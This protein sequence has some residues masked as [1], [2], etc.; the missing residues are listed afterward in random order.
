MEAFTAWP[1]AGQCTLAMPPGSSAAQ[2]SRSAC[3]SCGKAPGGLHV[4][5]L[6]RPSATQCHARADDVVCVVQK[7]Q[8][9]AS[10]RA[11]APGAAACLVSHGQKTSCCPAA[12]ASVVTQESRHPKQGPMPASC[13]AACMACRHICLLHKV[14][15]MLLPLPEGFAAYAAV[16]WQVLHQRSRRW[17]SRWLDQARL[18]CCDATAPLFLQHALV[19]MSPLSAAVALVHVNPGAGLSKGCTW[20]VPWIRIRCRGA[21]WEMMLRRLRASERPSLSSTSTFAFS[22]TSTSCSGRFG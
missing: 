19:S 11:M 5:K 6:N 21:M 10:D 15:Q 17:C 14:L 9:Q 22:R 20:A 16:A 18:R 4:H 1:T 7:A 3:V 12:P 2:A 8:R 13:T